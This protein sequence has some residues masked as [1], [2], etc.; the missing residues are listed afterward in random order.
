[1]AVNADLCVIGAGSAGLSVAAGA[2]MLGVPVVLIEKARMG[3]DCLNTGCVPSKALLAAAHAAQAVRGA[4]RFG[5]A[6]TI[7]EIDQQAA[8]AHVHRVIDAIAPV[9]SVARFE[10]LGVTVLQGE[11][12]FTSARDVRVGD[13]S[14]G[15]AWQTVSMLVIMR[16]GLR[17][18]LT[19][20]TAWTRPAHRPSITTRWTD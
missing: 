10:A 14:R 19:S 12:R 3:G 16:T 13:R 2:A 15:V 8:R 7:G 4:G 20:S 5:I 17:P 6:A 9:D 18:S 1:M 11:A